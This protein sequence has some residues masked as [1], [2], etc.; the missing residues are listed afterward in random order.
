MVSCLLEVQLLEEQHVHYNCQTE[1]AALCFHVG[2]ETHDG[3]DLLW[4]LAAP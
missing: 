3:N 1:N 4:G 2:W